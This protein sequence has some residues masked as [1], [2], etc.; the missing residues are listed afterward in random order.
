[1]PATVPATMSATMP[2]KRPATIPATIPQQCLNSAGNNAHNHAQ[3][4]ARPKA[5][6][7][8]HWPIFYQLVYCHKKVNTNIPITS[9]LA[10]VTD[11]SKER[12]AVIFSVKQSKD[13]QKGEGTA[14]VLNVRTHFP[15][16]TVS[17]PRR[18]ESSAKPLWDP[19]NSSA[20]THAHTHILITNRKHN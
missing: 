14:L 20:R 1:M 5:Q 6:S 19:P 11:I 10:A 4:I 9:H 12:T 17:R 16:N 15:I 8:T 3:N 13:V 18:P 7:L 2:S